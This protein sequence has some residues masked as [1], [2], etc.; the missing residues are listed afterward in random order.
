MT[1]VGERICEVSP[2]CDSMLRMSEMMLRMSEMMLRMS[3]RVLRHH[4]ALVN[5]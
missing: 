1:V 3:E 5:G 4:V 2:V